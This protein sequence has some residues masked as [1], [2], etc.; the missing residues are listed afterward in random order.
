VEGWIFGVW[1]V[2]FIAAMFLWLRY[3]DPAPLTER[4]R[5]PGTAGESRADMATDFYRTSGK[6]SSTLSP[7]MAVK[8]H[9]KNLIDTAEA[10]KYT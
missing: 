10:T 6:H 5:L 8:W 7:Y 4:L 1:W 9:E 3:R 2:S